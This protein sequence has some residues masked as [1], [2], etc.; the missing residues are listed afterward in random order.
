MISVAVAVLAFAYGVGG[1]FQFFRAKAMRALAYKWGFHYGD[2]DLPASFRMACY[3]ADTIR[4]AW[5]VVK[6]QQHGVT[7]LIFDSI[8]GEGGRGVYCTFVAIQTEM[9]PFENVDSH[10][11]IIKSSGWTAVYRL[12]FLQIPWTLSAKRIED[13]LNGAL[14]ASSVIQR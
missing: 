13:R 4:R 2:R 14:S 5:N 3:P 8:V 1:I 12:R 11:K 6:G 10:E 9:N 7:V